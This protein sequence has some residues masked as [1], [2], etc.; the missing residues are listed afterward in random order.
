MPQLLPLGFKLYIV[1]A[2]VKITRK[3]ISRFVKRQTKQIDTN[4][5]KITKIQGKSVDT[6]MTINKVKNF[7][8]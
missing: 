6:Y 3:V 5:K 7:K 1:E 4:T 8:L 2:C